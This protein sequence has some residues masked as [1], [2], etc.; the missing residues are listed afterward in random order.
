VLKNVLVTLAAALAAAVAVAAV[1]VN[2]AT[3]AE[4]EAVKG[5]GPGIAARILNERE[6]APFTDWDDLANRVK[7]VGQANAAKFSAAGLTVG[8]ATFKGA[9]QAAAGQGEN[10]VGGVEADASAAQK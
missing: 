7:G 1:D 2:K 3:Q 10:P 8:G 4:L 6:K 9:A 5:I